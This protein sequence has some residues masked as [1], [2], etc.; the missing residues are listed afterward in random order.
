MAR[1]SDLDYT[2]LS[3]FYYED[4]SLKEIARI[5]RKKPGYVKV[6]LQRARIKLYKVLGA[7]ARRELK[8]L[9]E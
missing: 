6:L 3:L 5:V 4:A 2:V 9:I 1:L 8:E 7:A